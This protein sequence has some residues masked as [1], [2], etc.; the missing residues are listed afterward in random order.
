[1][2]LYNICGIAS[3]I[4][5][6]SLCMGSCGGS[7]TKTGKD[8]DSTKDKICTGADSIMR[9]LFQDNKP[10]AVILIAKGDSVIFSRGYGLAD[11]MTGDSIDTQTLF[12]ICS[13]SKQFSAIALLKLQEQGLLSLDDKLVKYMP[14]YNV[15]ALKDITLRQMMSHTSGI[16]DSRPHT[17]A[18]WQ[19]YL[20]NHKSQYKNVKD[21]KLYA[22]WEESC[23]YLKDLKK[24]NFKP[25][26]AYEYMNPTFQLVEPI[27]ERLTGK[28]FTDWMKEE[29]FA[30][31]GM[32]NTIYLEPEKEM[33]KAAHGY[34]QDTNGKW[35]E[36][37][38]GEAYFFPTKADGGI[39]ANAE[40]FF[41]WQRALI[42]GRIVG[43]SSLAQAFTPLI[44]TDIA[45][46]SYGLGFFL[47]KKEGCPLK[48]FHTGD[49]GGFFTY[50]AII[51]EADISYLVFATRND[52][53]REETAEKIDK[54]LRENGLD[55]N[56]SENA[57]RSTN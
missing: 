23:Q 18:E 13:I 12:N 33:I 45:A 19:N 57:N 25:G 3:G 5:A 10:G 42:N 43:T 4:I 44:K 49:N 37:D 21:Y 50:E 28:K 29:I 48:I 34:E 9:S 1:M 52:W 30:P 55:A 36:M 53:S 6:A 14:E 51:P 27:V 32:K 54:L 26:D 41:R 11:M 46:T 20:H 17:E 39:Y 22:Q 38:Y 7:G 31:A 2:T 15:P 8:S 47:E 35:H 56:I 40:D 16:P 24:L